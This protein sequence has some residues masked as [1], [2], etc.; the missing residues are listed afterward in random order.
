MVEWSRTSLVELPGGVATEGAAMSN[1]SDESEKQRQARLQG[2]ADK[3][4]DAHPAPDVVTTSVPQRERLLRDARASVGD[5]AAACT[6]AGHTLTEEQLQQFLT[7]GDTERG[8][9]PG[10]DFDAPDVVVWRKVLTCL[11]GYAFSGGADFSRDEGGASA[12]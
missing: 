10:Y 8:A 6:L 1:R 12:S 2:Y 3:I 7:A 4:R 11:R 5:I 9:N